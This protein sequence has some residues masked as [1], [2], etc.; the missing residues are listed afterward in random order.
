MT[1]QALVLDSRRVLSTHAR[2]FRWAGALLD[3]ERLDDAAVTYSFCRAVDDAVDEAET[4]QLARSRLGRLVAGLARPHAVGLLGAYREVAKRRGFGL[5]PAWQLI[6]GVEGDLDGVRVA[7]DDELIRYAY[8]VAG[9]VGLMMF[10]ILGVS[11]PR[12]R[13]HAVDLGVA[14]QITNI[15]RDVLEDAERNRVYLPEDRLRAAG[16][17]A[18]ALVR[19]EAPASAVAEVVADLLALAERYYRSADA[20]MR[21]IPWRARLAI[22]VASR[23]YR[24]IGRVLQRRG[25]DPMRGRV[26]VSPLEK[27]LWCLWSLLAFPWVSGW[28]R[29]ETPHE[30]RL[31]HPIVD[32]LAPAG[33]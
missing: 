1:S 26:V 31:H 2:S 11:D 22:V 5:L 4:T 23:L 18:E 25:C 9:T 19:G 21:Y 30:G 6:D 24:A 16:T 33:V 7:D 17:D 12:A 8:R 10:G 3:D 15:C 29:T 28:L 32:L 20:G 14:M 13:A 27:V